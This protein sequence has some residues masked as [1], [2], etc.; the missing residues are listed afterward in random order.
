M[1]TRYCFGTMALAAAT[2]LAGC[3]TASLPTLPLPTAAYPEPTAEIY[4]RIAR[5]ALGCWF[6]T[7]GTLKRTHI[8]HADVAPPSD[9]AGAEIIIH[10]RD[11][12]AQSPRSFKTYRV[13][14]TPGPE[15]T[16]VATENIK[17]P[18][19]LASTM[20]EDVRRWAGGQAGCSAAAADGWP[21]KDIQRGEPSTGAVAPAVTGAKAR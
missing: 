9:K 5:G 19:P 17:L 15:G 3:S 10:E 14:I 4:S 16:F 21:V 12:A 2:A 20:T 11:D 18:E 7:S 13:R 1:R 8:F 6:S